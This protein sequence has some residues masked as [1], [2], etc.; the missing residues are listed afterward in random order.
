MLDLEKETEELERKHPDFRRDGS[1]IVQMRRREEADLGI[2]RYGI[3][4][5]NKDP[6][7][8]GRA[9]VASDL[10]GPGAVTP[11]IPV[12][13]L[14]ATKKTGWW[15]LPDIGTQV[16][17]AFVG[18]GRSNPVV[19][20]CLYDLKHLPPEHSTEKLRDSK[21]YQTRAHRLEFIDE[22]GKESIILSSAKGQ[23]RLVLSKEKGIELVNELGDIKIKCRKLTMRGDEGVRIEGKKRVT[24][25]GGEKIGIE[26]KKGIRIECGKEIKIKGKNIKLEASRGITTEGKQLAAEGDKVMGFDVHLMVVPSGKGTDVVPLPHP[27]IGKLADKLSRDVKIKGH[28]AAVKGSVAKHDDVAHN[29][30]P[31]TIKFQQNP[32]KEGEVTGGTGKKL[33]I[34]GKEPAVVGSTVTT[35]ND[36]GA[37]ENSAVIAPGASVPMPMIINPKNME[38]YRLEREKEQT[39]SPDITLADF[40]M[41][42]AGEGEKVM[43]TAQVKD[44][45]DGNVL[46]FQIWRKG[47]DPASHIPLAQKPK[48]VKDGGAEAEMSYE[49]PAGEPPPDEDPEFFFTA[50]SAWCQPRRS[51]YLKVRLRRPEVKECGWLDG[52]GNGTARGLAGETLRM[53]AGFN[54]DAEEG[55]GVTFRV[56]EQGADTERDKPVYEAGAAVKDGK[57][58]AEWAY[59]YRHDPENPLKE[60]PKYFFTVNSPRCKEAKSGSVEIGMDYYIHVKEAGRVVANTPCTVGLSDGST[61]KANTDGDGIIKLKAKVPGFALWVEYQNQKGDTR[62][63]KAAAKIIKEES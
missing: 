38:E 20:G 45:E 31:G 12:V 54:A 24:I 28:N 19:I 57:A 25:K 32:K 13:A 62:R 58:E 16:M 36:V 15:Q 42:S 47:Q 46:T 29:Q 41:G 49:H 11:W 39:R 48:S 10:L 22:E 59:H 5:D 14:G 3:V 53:S 8:L 60:K 2:P 50:H 43:L 23:I 56:Y 37:R 26:A 21:V 44:I 18:R 1:G 55:A 40:S 52:E 61:E 27:F 6:L 17:M 7:C 51:G 30:L 34:N 35:C 33:K 9:R 4:A 63:I